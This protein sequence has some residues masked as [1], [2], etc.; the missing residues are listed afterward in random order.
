ML[1]LFNDIDMAVSFVRSFDLSGG[2]SG[3]LLTR[4]ATIRSDVVDSG[5]DALVRLSRKFDGLKDLEF[6]LIVSKTDVSE[7]Y[8]RVSLEFLEALKRAKHAIEDYHRRQLPEDWR[9]SPSE[10]VVYGAQWTSIDSAGLYVPGG[11]G[12]YP[13]SVLM[14]A[15]PAKLA[16]VSK[17][18]MASPPQPDGRLPD[19]IVVAADLCGVDTIVKTGGAQA[20]FALAYGTNTI[21]KVDKIVGPGNSYVTAA[22]QMVYGL[23]DIDKPAGPSEVLVYVTD[24]NY[25]AYAASELLAQLEHDPESI[26]VCI[27]ESDETLEA[28]NRAFEEQF[29]LCQRQEIIAQ[30]AQRSVLLCTSSVEESLSAINLFSTEHLVLLTDD[31]EDLLSQVRHAGS[32]FCGPYTPVALG[33]YCAGP[34]HVLP[35]GS[36]ARFASPLGVLDFMKY[37]AVT[38][39]TKQALSKISKTVD[40]LSREEGFDA[41]RRSVSVRLQSMD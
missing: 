6:R 1:R 34:N 16:G 26:A 32:I 41:H 12:I 4:V 31:F 24:P 25:A 7:A 22:K 15:I 10:G 5:D 39:F 38:H 40:V 9:V 30:S 37:S 33:D 21:P 11:R 28:V 27:S 19:S 20:V 2:V 36:T 17:L 29:Q 14:N 13:S 23:V 35:T 8:E 18:V 3:D